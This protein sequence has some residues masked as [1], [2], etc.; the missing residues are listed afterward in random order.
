MQKS[1]PEK[2]GQGSLKAWLRAGSKEAAQVLPAF[3]D[4]IQPV[5]EPGLPGNLTPQEVHN[6]KFPEREM[7]PDR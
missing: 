5:E 6:Q 7:E 1:E 2:F 3:K 4:S